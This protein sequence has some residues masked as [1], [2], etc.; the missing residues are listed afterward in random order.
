M[1]E[2]HTTSSQKRYWKYAQMTHKPYAKHT[3]GTHDKCR[4]ARNKFI[5]NALETHKH[6]TQTVHETRAQ[7]TRKKRRNTQNRFTISNENTQ[8]IHKHAT[9]S[10]KKALEIYKNDAQTIRASHTQ[11]TKQLQNNMQQDH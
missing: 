10:Q 9:S 1:Q 7:N 5:K 6:D 4:N 11:H 8:K 2:Q 3:Q